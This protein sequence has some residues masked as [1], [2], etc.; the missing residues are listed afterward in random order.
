MKAGNPDFC[1]KIMQVAR[2]PPE[3][4]LLRVPQVENHCRTLL[5]LSPN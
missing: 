1:I 5:L 3:K 2:I 4:P